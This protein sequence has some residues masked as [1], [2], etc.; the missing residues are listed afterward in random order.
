VQDEVLVCGQG[1]SAA[2]LP[3]PAERGPPD[4]PMASNPDLS[5]SGALAVVS[6]PCA[7]LSQGCGVGMDIFGGGTFVVRAVGK[8]VDPDSCCEE[9]GEATNPARLAKDV[10]SALKRSVRKKPDKSNRIP[11][12]L[13]DP[14]P[15][16]PAAGAAPPP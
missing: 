12:P 15:Q 4:R 10:W 14:L 13:D 6:S 7:T 1:D 5:G 11:I 3:L 2:R 16:A 9:P 8:L